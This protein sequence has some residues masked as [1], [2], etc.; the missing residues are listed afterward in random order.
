M[1]LKLHN[2]KWLVNEADRLLSVMVPVVEVV[3]TVQYFDSGQYSCSTCESNK[4][5]IREHSK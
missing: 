5:V 4:G 3:V 2:G 1:Q